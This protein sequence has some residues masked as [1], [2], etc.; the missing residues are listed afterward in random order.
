V[1][2]QASRYDLEVEANSAD[3]YGLVFDWTTS[4][5]ETMRAFL[6][7]GGQFTAFNDNPVTGVPGEEVTTWLAGAGLTRTVRLTELF[8][9]ATHSVGPNSSGFVIQRDQLRFRVTHLFTPRFSLFGGV[10]GT[11]DD[12]LES[13]TLFRPRNYATG[14]VGVEWRVWQQLSLIL[15]VDY[16]WQD[17]EG[18][19]PASTSGGGTLSFVYEP[20]RH[21]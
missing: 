13:E 12:G 17:F 11:R 9:D 16:T 7:A 4:A 18:P 20:R 10:R 14:D 1:S 15:S 3:A 8:L 6:R 19:L 21:D 2:A 5:T